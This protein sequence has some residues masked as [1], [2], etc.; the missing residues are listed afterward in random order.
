MNNETRKLYNG[1]LAALAKFNQVESAR[2]QFTVAPTIQQRLEN[3]MQESSTF[4]QQINMVGVT[5][6]SGSK[7]GLGIG[8]TIASRTN[9]DTTDRAPIDPTSLDE[10]GYTCRK[11]DFDTAIKYKK[12]DQWAKFPD[13][14]ARI[15]NAIVQRQALDRIMIGW[16]GTSAAA[17][18]NRVA[19][20]LLQDVN[21]G[22]IQKVRT[23]ALTKV[24]S[25]GASTGT[26]AI[27]IG[28]TGA[29]YANLDAL[30]YDVVNNLIDPWYRQDPGL[31]VLLGRNLLA[32]KYFPL[33]NSTQPATE[34]LATDLI[35][36]QKRVGGLQAV[37]V[38][39]FPENSIVITRLDNLSIYYQDGARR[40]TIIDNPKR[41]QIENYES[42]ND[43]FVVE[44]YGLI[45]VAENIT[46]VP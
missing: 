29:D 28:T 43:D 8:S 6:Q 17:T 26:N 20:P 30:V 35:I 9:T 36:S 15:R 19:N 42:S 12:L 27:K 33:V 45:A 11:T 1:F 40:R 22:W 25:D 5:E 21:I 23:D 3:R 13:F 7:V 10:F 46:F 39:Y 37:T 34:Q 16:N 31:R 24:I 32:D 38:P 41:D 4:L 14:Q 44:D 18:T 2:E